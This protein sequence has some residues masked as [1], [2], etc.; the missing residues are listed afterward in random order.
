[1]E[2]KVLDAHIPLPLAE[3]LDALAFALG[4]PRD[5]IVAEAIT[6]W[7]DQEEQRRLVA[8]RTIAAANTMIV[9]EHH[10]VID[11]ADSL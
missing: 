6:A 4:L 1:M 3:R 8:L 2:T 10:R 9:V 5:E 11:W 7:L